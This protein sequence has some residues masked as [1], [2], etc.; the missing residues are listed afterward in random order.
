MWPRIFF[1]EL[2][3]VGGVGGGLTDNSIFFAIREIGEIN[4]SSS[5]FWVD[6]REVKVKKFYSFI[7]VPTMPWSPFELF[8][9]KVI[10]AYCSRNHFGTLLKSNLAHK[11][12][13]SNTVLAAHDHN[14]APH[15]P[16][17][18]LGGLCPIEKELTSIVVSLVTSRKQNTWTLVKN[19]S[20]TISKIFHV[21]N[22]HIWK[23]N[24]NLEKKSYGPHVVS[25]YEIVFFG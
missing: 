12:D 3:V 24:K 9:D 2:E 17:P 14:S 18:S 25:V 8:T 6:T 11:R 13:Q 7:R 16:H 15:G 21:I 22:I 4:S 19:G 5:L 10:K 1:F 23:E 20:S